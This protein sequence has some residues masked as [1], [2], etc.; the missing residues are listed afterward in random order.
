MTIKTVDVR[1]TKLG[2]NELLS[3]TAEGDEVILTA[4]STPLARLVPLAS[5]PS[6]T[7]VPGL[8]QGS[9]WTSTDFDE[10]LP[11]EFWTGAA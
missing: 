10:P 8:H 7:R 5:A 4:G 11:D 1:E 2:L 3:M 6:G 9:I